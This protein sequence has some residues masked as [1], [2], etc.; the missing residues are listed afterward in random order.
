MARRRPGAIA[1]AWLLAALGI[2][3]WSGTLPPLGAAPASVGDCEIVKVWSNGFHTDLTFPAE[4]L[5]ANHPLRRFDPNARYMLVGWGDEAS[6]RSNGDNIWIGLESLLPGGATI[7]HVVYADQPVEQIY[8]G[9]SATPLA[10]SRA[11]AAQIA[12][13]L[14]EALVLD[15]DGDA[16]FIAPGHGGPRSYFLKGQGEFDLFEVCNQWLARTLRAAGVNINAA[17]LYTGTL[18]DIAIAGAPHVCP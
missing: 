4:L 5:P 2:W 13:R 8:R 6:F 7:V 18:I 14:T 16:Q 3:F 15:R 12:R 11:G 1:F 9:D 10:I 17:F